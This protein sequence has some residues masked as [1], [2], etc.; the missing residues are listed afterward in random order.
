[1]IKFRDIKLNINKK[2]VLKS[3]SGD[4]QRNE[5]T[6]I[7]GMSGSGKSTLLK[8]IGGRS[9]FKF[10]GSVSFDDKR[11]SSLD[12]I[13]KS[14]YVHQFDIL[15]KHETVHG[16]LSFISILK[17]GNPILID[18]M[19][20]DLGMEEIKNN[21]IGDEHHKGISGGERKRV[22]IAIELLTKPNSDILFLDEPTTG[23]DSFSA[24]KMLRLVKNLNK[25]VITTIHQPSTEALKIFK[26]LIVL[27]HGEIIYNGPV[28]KLTD[29]MKKFYIECPIYSNPADF[30]FSNIIPGKKFPPIKN[31]MEFNSVQLNKNSELPHL[32][33]KNMKN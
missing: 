29:Y 12:V 32:E 17:K 1:M 9:S 18:R 24:Y 5:M 16:Y 2:E 11:M 21:F 22:S 28:N 6:A 25:T 23:L 10:K 20:K 30:L 13:N 33:V 27:D 4:I 3:I 7:M 8:I 31:N 26:N 14:A 19:I 15:P